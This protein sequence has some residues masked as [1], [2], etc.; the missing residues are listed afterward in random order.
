MKKPLSLQ[1]FHSYFHYNHNGDYCFAGHT[2]N[3][4]EINVVTKGSLSITYDDQI[5]TLRENM[6][7]IC[8]SEVFHRNRVLTPDGAELFVYH[9]YVDDLPRQKE[10]RVY[11]LDEDTLALVRLIAYEAGKTTKKN[12]DD[13]LSTTTL[14]YQSS[15]L[16]EILLMRLTESEYANTS[17]THPDE[18][19]YKKAILFMYDNISRALTINEI[20]SHCHVSPTKIKNI[21]SEFAGTGVI[22]HFSQMKIN[23][24]KRMLK[25]GLA[26]GEISDRLGYSSQGYLSLCFKKQTGLSP[27]AYKKRF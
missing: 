19:L 9:F 1:K 7:M 5:V 26:I 21:F 13:A 11:L 6:L 23:E 14:N 24:A 12:T 20:A 8:E 18:K 2:H 17:E 27:L 16:L 10:A 4:W 22:T 25:K 15:K 3:F